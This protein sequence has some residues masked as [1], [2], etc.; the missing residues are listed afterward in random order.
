MVRTLNLTSAHVP[1]G[2]SPAIGTGMSIP[3]VQVNFGNQATPA[4]VVSSRTPHVATA[5]VDLD[6]MFLQRAATP[7]SQQQ[8][9][10]MPSTN[11]FGRSRGSEPVLITPK[12]Y[13]ALNPVSVD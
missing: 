11:R 5:S 10:V 7:S 6:A 9:F 12:H 1:P 2:K 4:Q 3:S 13:N 8:Q